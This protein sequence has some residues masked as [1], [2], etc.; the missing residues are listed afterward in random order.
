LAD[1]ANADD[2]KSHTFHVTP[3]RRPLTVCNGHHRESPPGPVSTIEEPNPVE[4]EEVL[5]LRRYN[6]E[7]LFLS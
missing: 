3:L 5:M 2:A 6:P 1:I 4:L 7:R